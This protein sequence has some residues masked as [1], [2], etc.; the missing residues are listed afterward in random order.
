M[1]RLFLQPDFA[2]LILRL[3]LA[4]IFIVQGALKIMYYDGGTT[5]YRYSADTPLPAAL[6]ATVAYGEV[7][8]GIAFL[9]G[10]LTR[11]TALGAI[12]IMF[13]AMYHVTWRF[14]FTS[15]NE[16]TPG[17][18]IRHEVGYEYNLAIM[19]MSI[20]LII[21]GGGLLSVD[22]MLFHRK[23]QPGSLNMNVA[24]QQVPAKMHS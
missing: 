8:I 19:A 3:M 7:V 18:F 23:Q 22:H 20:C 1:L 16:G 12:A 13:G 21:L 5:W 9:L 24:E 17:G 6:Q 15:L 2:A 4:S 10:L 11:L 14:D